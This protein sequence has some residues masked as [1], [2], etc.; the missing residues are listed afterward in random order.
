MTAIDPAGSAGVVNIT[1]QTPAGTSATS[2][3]DQFTYVILAPAV[4][5]V[6]P[7]TGTSDGGTTVTIT[8]TGLSGATGVLFG[9]TPAQGFTVNPDGTI[10]AVSPAG[11]AGVVDITVQSPGGT[12]P[13]DP[14]RPV[15]LRHPRPGRDRRQPEHRYQHRWDDGDHHRHAPRTGVH[16]RVGHSGRT[17][18]SARRLP[19]CVTRHAARGLARPERRRPERRSSLSETEPVKKPPSEPSCRSSIRQ[20]IRRQSYREAA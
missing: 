17:W 6:S 15:H 19:R 4:T 13:T 10:T 8:G 11:V 2:S 18:R 7:N 1:V 20:A 5:G 14:G 9:T 16:A 3:A 12:S